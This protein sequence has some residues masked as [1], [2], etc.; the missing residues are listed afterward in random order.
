MVDLWE[1]S[2]QMCM[3]F[4]CATLHIK[5]AWGIFGPSDNGLQQQEEQEQPEWLFGTRLPSTINTFMATGSRQTNS[6]DKWRIVTRTV[7]N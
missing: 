3:Q 6:Y 4:R 5:K 1:M 2:A 7:K